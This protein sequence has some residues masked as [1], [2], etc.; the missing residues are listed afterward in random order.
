MMCGG[1]MKKI[2][3]ALTPMA[4]VQSARANLSARRVTV[5]WSGAERVALSLLERLSDIG[6][7]AMPYAVDSIESADAK[8]DRQFLRALA[9]AGFGAANIMLLSVAVWSGLGGD[10]DHETR[11]LFHWVSALIAVPVVAFSGRPFFESAL[12]ALRAKRM[13]MD[14]PISLAILLAVA[15]SLGQLIAGGEHAYFDAAVTLLFFLLI[16]RYLDQHMR[17]RAG[18]AVKDL[19]ALKSET[20]IRLCADGTAETVSS[21]DLRIGDRIF[22]PAGFVISADGRVVEGQSDLDVS[23]MTGESLPASV[24]PTSEVSRVPQI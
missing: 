4:G 20:T 21:D 13:N 11:Q 14:V 24:G 3:T 1:C 19:L 17:R 15:S 23:V 2:E 7:E 12:T 10:M 5:V 9:V 16:G 22:V 8:K 6:F 18:S